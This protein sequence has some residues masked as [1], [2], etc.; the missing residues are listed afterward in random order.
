VFLKILDEKVF[1]FKGPKT[2]MLKG[3]SPR[4][5]GAPVAMVLDTP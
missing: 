2:Q 4:H 5:Y 1:L 3:A